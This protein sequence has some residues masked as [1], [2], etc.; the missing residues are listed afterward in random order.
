VIGSVFVT[1]VDQPNLT[2]DQIKQFLLTAKM[3][4]SHQS[5]KGI[6]KS[7]RLQRQPICPDLRH[8]VALA[9]V[10]TR[11]LTARPRDDR[12]CPTRRDR[13]YCQRL[14]EVMGLADLP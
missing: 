3:I 5:A 13:I 10:S 7:S 14:C 6:T 11:L 12:S 4:A 2:K 8:L 1:A 9:E